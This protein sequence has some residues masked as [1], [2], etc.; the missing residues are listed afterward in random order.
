[1]SILVNQE[2]RLL[3]QGI[4]GREGQFHGQAM[5]DYG[6][7][8]VSGVTPGKG[9]QRTFNNRVPVFN[10]VEEAIRETGANTSVIYVPAAFAPD[11]MLEAAAAGIGLIFCITEGI[12]AL[13]MLR[14]YHT[15][16]QQGVRLIGPN[17]PGATSVGQAKVGIIPGN[18]HR[19]GT[20]G[21]VSRSGT[22]T[23]E[24]VQALTDE[25]L[26]QSTCVGIGGDPIIGTNFIEILD[27][28]EADPET[29][30]VVLIGE[31]GGD[32]EERAA[33]HIAEHLSKPVT[34][35]I[36]GRTAPPGRR[37]GHAGAIISGGAGTAESK[38]EALRKAG[39]RV[40]DSPLQI[41]AL[42]RGPVG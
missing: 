31:I 5:L 29:D 2:T 26:G 9:G 39:V 37:M 6:T 33:A 38:R 14:V 42:V 18:I 27:L 15:L 30:A 11:A 7:P 35:F 20:V 25:G 16:R 4:T 23:Y 17:C 40:A 19:R 34:A 28:F 21:V 22:L 13:D 12:P 36:A 8:V 3:I 10:T 32:E 24:V 41:P 1:V